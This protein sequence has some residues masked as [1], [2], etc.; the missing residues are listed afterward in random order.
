MTDQRMFTELLKKYGLNYVFGTFFDVVGND[1]VRFQ[2]TFVKAGNFVK[3]GNKYAGDLRH[4][5]GKYYTDYIRSIS[6]EQLE[7]ELGL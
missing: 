2:N 1:T 5:S 4:T 7:K 6:I 3:T